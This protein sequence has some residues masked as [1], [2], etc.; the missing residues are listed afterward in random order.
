MNSLAISLVIFTSCSPKTATT[1]TTTLTREEIKINEVEFEFLSIKSK[2]NFEE[3]GNTKNATALIR[4]KKDS[5][6][7][8][9]L[10]GTLGV[11]GMRGLLTHDSIRMVNRVDKEYY[12]MS[13]DQ[14]SKEFNFDIDYRLIQAMILGEMPVDQQ[15]TESITEEGG[16]FIIHQAV[17]NKYIDNYIN[18]NT[19]KVTEVSVTEVDTENSLKLLYG[20]FREI[21]SHLFPFS[22]FVSL[23]HTNEFGELETKV[24]INHGKVSFS[25]KALSFPYSVPKKYVKK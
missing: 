11:Q 8:F 25:D 19:R 5:V 23:I 10:S 12:S 24:T 21:D 3:A 17:G 13:Y 2:I 4:M 16:R 9:N 22:S 7:W 18:T 20:D 6:I 1:S 15:N 14:L